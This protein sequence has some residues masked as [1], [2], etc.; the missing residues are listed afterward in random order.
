[1]YSN[2]CN[3]RYFS[4]RLGWLF[5]GLGLAGAAFPA[6]LA[7][8]PEDRAGDPDVKA[9][10]GNEEISRT[11]ESI[12]QEI[13]L[14]A[15]RKRIYEA[16]TEAQQFTKVM[17]LSKFPGGPAAMIS[18]KAGGPFSLFGDRIVGRHVELVPN[19][20][21]VQAW[22]AAGWEPGTYSIVR[23]DLKE[24][25][26]QTKIVFDH[27]AFP[28]GQAEHLLDGWNSNYWEPLAKYLV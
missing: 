19:E 26:G 16:L 7:G 28:N 4:L 8:T 23:F 21:L 18:R 10:A 2:S 13:V 20:R 5:S 17:R 11:A 24:Q 27:M 25:G 6:A 3:R 22:R 1:M 15:S 9:L 12:H 14:K